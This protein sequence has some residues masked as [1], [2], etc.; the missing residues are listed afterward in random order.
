M[1]LVRRARRY[2]HLRELRDVDDWLTR[3]WSD[4]W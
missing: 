4:A 2:A 1:L 3:I